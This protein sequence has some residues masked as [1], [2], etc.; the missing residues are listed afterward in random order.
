MQFKS[1]PAPKGEKSLSQQLGREGGKSRFTRGD[2]SRKIFEEIMREGGKTTR[3]ALFNLRKEKPTLCSG[4]G[5][6]T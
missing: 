2:F 1:R 3:K 5:K 6:R 4:P